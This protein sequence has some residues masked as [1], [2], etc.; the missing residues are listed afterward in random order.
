MHWLMASGTSTCPPS[1]E[2]AMKGTSLKRQT[3]RAFAAWRVVAVMI[4]GGIAWATIPARAQQTAQSLVYAV[5]DQETGALDA[6]KAMQQAQRERVIRMQSYAVISKDTKGKVHVQR[7]NQK[8]GTIAGTVI[9]GL[10]GALGGPA[11]AA[12]GATA[13]GVAGRATGEAVGIPTQDIKTIKQ[14]LSPGSS[15]LI[16]VV[17]ERWADDLSR[18]LQQTEARRVLESKIEPSAAGQEPS[19]TQPAQPSPPPSPDTQPSPPSPQP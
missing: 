11:G 5:Y 6:F 12:V 16:A 18:S 19:S 7:S 3:R 14:S 1:E 9:G 8:K 4:A 17:D 15:A 2:E 13:G 10:I